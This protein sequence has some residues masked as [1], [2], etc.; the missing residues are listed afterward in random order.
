MASFDEHIHQAKR[1]LNFLK[2][3][4]NH[5]EDCFDWQVT[6]CFYASLHIVNAH[7]SKYNLQYRKHSDVNHAINFTT[8]F[9]SKLP[10]DIYLA[11]M[12]LQSLSRRSRYLANDKDNNLNKAHAFYTYEKHLA[13]SF[14]H[15]ETLLNYFNSKYKIDLHCKNLKCIEIKNKADFKFVSFD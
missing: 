5:I 6:V 8:Y 9:P 14:R 11:Y 12:S 10:E 1:N 3:I 7:L 13:K 2:N 15:L 4:N